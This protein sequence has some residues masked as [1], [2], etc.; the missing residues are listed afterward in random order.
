[1]NNS[2]TTKPKRLSQAYRENYHGQ[3][4]VM[5]DSMEDRMNAD[6]RTGHLHT[7]KP[8]PDALPNINILAYGIYAVALEKFCNQ[9]TVEIR[10]ESK[11]R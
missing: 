1:M 7:F 10:Q 9:L 8:G 3:L 2:P 11:R 4:D 6:N 5:L